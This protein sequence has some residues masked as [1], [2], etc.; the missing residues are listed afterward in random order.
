MDTTD[1]NA[2]GKLTH[3]VK[4]VRKEIVE[5]EKKDDEEFVDVK[6]EAE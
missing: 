1:L 6:E 3:D 2:K 4:T 5:E